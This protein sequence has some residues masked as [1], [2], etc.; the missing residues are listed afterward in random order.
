MRYLRI[1]KLVQ[2][3]PNAKM[4]RYRR[5]IIITFLCLLLTGCFVSYFIQSIQREKK[6]AKAAG[7]EL[8]PTSVK[9]LLRVRQSDIWSR[10]MIEKENHQTFFKK[11]IPELYLHLFQNTP[12]KQLLF[13]FHPEG[14]VCYIQASPLEA[15]TFRTELA[16]TLNAYPPLKQRKEGIDFY[17]YADKNNQF[18]SCFYASGFWISSYN[19]QLLEKVK[20][21]IQQSNK[22]S[23]HSSIPNLPLSEELKST[24][25]LTWHDGHRWMNTDISFFLDYLSFFSVLPYAQPISSLDTAIVDT[26]RIRLGYHLHLPVDS[27]ALQ[28]SSDER[29]L[30][31]TVSI[32]N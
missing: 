32:K 19:A 24:T 8:V 21:Q 5:E 27:L 17:Y 28:F 4:K 22:N 11:Y 3:F 25:S 6:E 9:A 15:R 14:V 18:A 12:N 31:I 1:K 16:K 30:Y 29:N 2:L 13:S 20:D 26:F 7:Y 10:Y 23:Y